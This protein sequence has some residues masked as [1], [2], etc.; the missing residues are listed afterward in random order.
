MSVI[1]IITGVAEESNRLITFASFLMCSE[2]EWVAFGMGSLS[3]VG[4]SQ[5]S[6]HSSLMLRGTYSTFCNALV[7]PARR[8]DESIRGSKN[9]SSSTSSC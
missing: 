4:G 9:V 5:T 6:A 1:S 8:F 3:Q 7:Y 2:A